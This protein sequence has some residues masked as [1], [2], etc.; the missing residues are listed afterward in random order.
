MKRIIT[1]SVETLWEEDEFFE[2]VKSLCKDNFQDFELSVC[3]KE[4]TLRYKNE[5]K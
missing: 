2:K 5:T 3:G 1:I 4:K